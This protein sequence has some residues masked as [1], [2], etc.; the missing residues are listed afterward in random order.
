MAIDPA[1]EREAVAVVDRYYAALNA[2]DEDGVRD[3]FHFPHI[4]I[5][6]TGDVKILAAPADFQF[7]TFLA[8]MRQDGWHHSA[9]DKTEVVFTTPSKAHIAVNFTRYRADN[10]VI[11]RYFSLYIITERAGQWAIH[12]GSGDGT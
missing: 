6:K 12:C 8:R 11:G 5:G 4:R 7:N 3:V 2:N 10:S 1:I 9:W